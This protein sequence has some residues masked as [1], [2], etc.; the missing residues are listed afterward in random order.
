[1]KP[2]YIET[3]EKLYEIFE[4]YKANL[5]PREIQKATATGVKS[6]WHTPPLTMEGFEVYGHKVGVT[7]SHYFRNQDNRYVEYC[8]ICQRIKQEIRQDQIEG[9]MVGQFNPSITQRLN[10]LTEKTDITT[11]GDRISEIRINIIKPD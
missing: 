6:E 11:Q 9:G 8:E 1:M 2:K 5:K 7:V 10:G 4:G 3:P